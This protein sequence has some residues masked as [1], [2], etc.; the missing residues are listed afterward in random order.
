MEPKT[1]AAYALSVALL[2]LSV[3]LHSPL[4]AIAT[5]VLFALDHARDILLKV[6]ESKDV[7][8]VKAVINDIADNVVKD[9][10]RIEQLERDLNAALVRVRETLGESF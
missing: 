10:A 3:W 6:Q 5:V 1:I 7:T 2:C 9:R 8:E 4:I